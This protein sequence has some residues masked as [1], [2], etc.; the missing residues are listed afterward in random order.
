MAITSLF[1]ET[2]ESIWGD[3]F[4]VKKIM[5]VI[6]NMN[7]GINTRQKITLETIEVRVT[8]KMGKRMWNILLE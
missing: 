1:D 7:S 6:K 8:C 5:I 3:F 4:L 2:G